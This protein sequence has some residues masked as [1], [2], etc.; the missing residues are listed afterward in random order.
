MRYEFTIISA[1][2]EDWYLFE[3]MKVKLIK[4]G[5]FRSLVIDT[6][7]NIYS[8]NKFLLKKIED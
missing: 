3:G 1:S 7:F 6:A 4:K 8:V 2:Y 5:V